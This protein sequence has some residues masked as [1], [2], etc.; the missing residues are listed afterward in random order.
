M[1]LFICNYSE[2]V[3]QQQQQ[4]QQQNYT[5]TSTMKI[6]NQSRYELLKIEQFM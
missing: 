4:Q 3:K 6:K 5:I 1:L 2:A